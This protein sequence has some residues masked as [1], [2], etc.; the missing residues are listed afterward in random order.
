MAT[1]YTHSAVGLGLARLYAD[2]PMPWSYW[3]LAAAL[4]IVPDLDAFSTA[5][6]G[7]LLGHRGI[8]H[9]FVFALVLSAVAAGATF[10]RFKVRWWSLACL[11]FV[12]VAS[13]GLLDA[14]T[15]GGENIALF[16]PFGGRYGNWGLIHVSDI[17]FEL[18]DP[19]HSRALQDELLRVWLPMAVVVGTVMAYRRWKRYRARQSGAT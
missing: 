1:I 6:Y 18:P 7:T 9:T 8:T 14:M 2:R 11:F 5:A 3:I 19:R 10:R 4:P 12:I 15:W 17:A 13:H 16:W